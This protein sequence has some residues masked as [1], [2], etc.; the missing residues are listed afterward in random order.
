MKRLTKIL[1]FKILL[2]TTSL[3]FAQNGHPLFRAVT[4]YKVVWQEKKMDNLL[5]PLASGRK[6]IRGKK[7]FVSYKSSYKNDEYITKPI[8]ILKKFTADISRLGGK[9]VY[10]NSNYAIFKA[11]KEN[12]SL[13]L[14]VEIYHNG[15]EY[16]IAVL[17]EANKSDS[18]YDRLLT[19]GYVAI[20]IN[21]GSSKTQVPPESMDFITTIAEMMQNNPKL[22]LSIEGHTDNVGNPS[23][24]KTLS[25]KRAQS[26]KHE[27]E[28][29]GI[30]ANR[31][32]FVGWGDKRPISNNNSEKGRFQNR[33]VRL[34][35]VNSN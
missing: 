16:C 17:E 12:K 31:L 14:V 27:I 35:K 1:I 23:L 3:S 26:V 9:K 2:L 28:G 11:E 15:K 25:E 30:A 10:Q 21:F 13:W 29:K 18:M 22:H 20:H 24:N 6:N 33:R 5:I 34:V 19:T 4:D 7:T 32:T 8:D